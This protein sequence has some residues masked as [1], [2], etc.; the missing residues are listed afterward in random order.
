MDKDMTFELLEEL[1]DKI[2]TYPHVSAEN[3]VKLLKF[4]GKQGKEAEEQL[5]S[6]LNSIDDLRL[7][8]KYLLFDLESTRRENS[9][10]KKLLD[11]KES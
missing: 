10:F 3:R 6:I 1:L 5:S 4:V 7:Y 2:G 11:E 9:Y 8:M